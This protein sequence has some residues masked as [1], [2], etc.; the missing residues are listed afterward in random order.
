MFRVLI[1]GGTEDA[2]NIA[3]ELCRLKIYVTVNA[4]TEYTK[5]FYTD[6]N[7]LSLNI[8]KMNRTE[9]YNFIM[10]DNYSVVIDATHPF[11]EEATR[12]IK[13]AC[14]DTGV[15]YI[16]F[17]RDIEKA[18]T[19]I[20]F[21]DYIS[22]IE[23]LNK[24]KG[25]IF[26]TTGSKNIEL[27]K[28][29]FEYKERLY[30]RILP[31]EESISKCRNAGIHY[32]NIICMNGPFSTE[33]NCAM[34]KAVNAKYLVTKNSGRTGGFFE[35]IEACNKLDIVPLVL[36]NPF[37][38]EGLDFKNIINEVVSFENSYSR[39]CRDGKY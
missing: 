28:D 14:S 13:S 6:N 38:K 31:F 36:N 25:N 39:G 5:Q 12:N 29:I 26:L 35:K 9:M 37:E 8:N 15:K 7:F 17:K 16:R 19:G 18:D 27:F 24:T 1:F 11:A 34:L 4:V 32:K 30:V 22:V 3:Y 23:Y 2:K 21:N 20:Y 33:L 10:K